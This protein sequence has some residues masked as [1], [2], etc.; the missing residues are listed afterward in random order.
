MSHDATQTR[1]RTGEP[2]KWWI[3][4]AIA[5]FVLVVALAAPIMYQGGSND[6]ASGNIAAPN[7]SPTA[8]V[9]DTDCDPLFQQ[10]EVSNENNRVDNHFSDLV[11]EARN[12]PGSLNANLRDAL[13]ERSAQNGMLLATWSSTVGLHEDPNDWDQLVDGDCLSEEGQRL[14]AQFEGALKA[15]GTSVAIGE[16][17]E[18]GYNSGVNDGVFGVDANPGVRGDRTAVMITMKDG[19]KVYIMVRCGN[20]VYPGKPNLPEVPTDN[21]PPPTTPPTN[22]PPPP[23]PTNEPKDPSEDPYP[24]GNAPVG[25]GPNADPGPGTYIPPQQMQQ[26]PSQPR[27]DPPPPA[28]QPAPAP[29][30]V[31]PSP[32]PAT[33]P[34]VD[35]G[36]QDNDGTVPEEG[37]A[38]CNPD[39]QNC[40]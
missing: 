6:A 11:N 9:S 17:P 35:T 10:V 34:T 8:S 23:P 15:T 14:H 32:A 36:E 3:A 4:A 38:N 39:F 21:P 22:P 20:P 40:P 31:T 5:A 30:T 16:A 26:P 24:R 13:L 27:V 1:E 19:S 33:P 28:P 12:Q 2:K 37:G 25:G 29:P 7:P 18:N